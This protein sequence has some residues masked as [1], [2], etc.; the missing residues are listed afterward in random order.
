MK[1]AR[2]SEL[3]QFIAVGRISLYTLTLIR[4]T[5]IISQTTT[6]LIAEFYLN[7]RLPLGPTLAVVL[8]SILPNVAAAVQTRVFL[9]SSVNVK[10]T[11]FYLG[12]DIIQL[13]ILLYLTGGHLNPFAILLLLPL[14]VSAI[15][16][17]WRGVF[18]ITLLVLICI[19]ILAL[20]H[21]SSPG[22]VLSMDIASDYRV[23]VQSF[24]M[25]LSLSLTAVFIAVYVWQIGDKSRQTGD[26]LLTSQIKLDREKRIS[27]IGAIAT[28]VAHELRTPLN[29]IALVSRELAQELPQDSLLMGDITLIC[30]QTD[31]CC[32]ILAGLADRSGITG[33]ESCEHLSLL[34]LIETAANPHQ[35]PEIELAVETVPR[36]NSKMPMFRQNLAL[37]HSISNLLQNALQFARR[38][39]IVCA[40]WSHKEI[41]VTITDDGLGFP[42][43]LL[44]RL[45]EPY[46]SGRVGPNEIEGNYHMGLGIFIASTL[47]ERGGAKLRFSNSRQGGAQVSVRWNRHNFEEIWS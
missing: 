8:M 13:T 23:I 42:L 45:G 7:Y 31:R 28:A 32:R 2:A 26:S 3:A 5:A 18:F 22:A 40:E 33:G 30:S 11:T 14:T 15:V 39:V 47:L 38:R 37:L 25:W 43:N 36:D 21:Y 35:R 16:L 29:T 17:S 34:A 9:H 12:Y 24:G 10:G 20:A 6:L 27:T 46:I 4:W 19:T 1:Q 44:S 41:Y